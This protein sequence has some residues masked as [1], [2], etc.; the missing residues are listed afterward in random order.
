MLF[1]REKPYRILRE[2]ESSQGLC[3]LKQLRTCD[4]HEFHAIR[5]TWKIF[6]SIWTILRILIPKFSQ[7]A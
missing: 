4:P 1:I 6:D 5:V 2:T 3:S 7:T